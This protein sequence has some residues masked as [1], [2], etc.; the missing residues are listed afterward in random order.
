M[1]LEMPPVLQE[2]PQMLRGM[3]QV[4]RGA[5]ELRDA[6]TSRGGAKPGFGFI[7]LTVIVNIGWSTSWGLEF[8][9]YLMVGPFLY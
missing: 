9:E 7:F 3:S 4:L 6:A 1:L 5:E 2:M 8:S